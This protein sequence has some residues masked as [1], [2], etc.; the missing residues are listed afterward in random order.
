MLTATM[1]KGPW[2]NLGEEVIERVALLRTP[3]VRG[4][5]PVLDG[6]GQVCPSGQHWDPIEGRCAAARLTISTM[7]R[8]APA[9]SASGLIPLD[10]TGVPTVTPVGP[11]STPKPENGVFVPVEP[12]SPETPFYKK[13]W[14]WG[15]AGA[16]G[17]GG[18]VFVVAR[19][20]RR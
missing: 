6:F 12:A 9:V 15:L 20:R 4:P 14:F 13:G 17:L 2:G 8:K 1:I 16:A 10:P 19:K 5:L 18:I 3:R 7:Q 11:T